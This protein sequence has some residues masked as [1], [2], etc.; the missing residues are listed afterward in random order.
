M[1]QLTIKVPTGKGAE[2]KEK[3]RE[4]NGKNISVQEAVT[5]DL[6]TVYLSNSNVSQFIA[7]IDHLEDAEI[8]LAPRGFI[9]LYPPQGDA[10]DQVTD[11]TY[12]SPIEIFLGGLQSVGSKTGLLV[13]SV[14]GA[15]LVW[16]G[17]YTGTS[18]LLV[19]AMLVAPFAGPAMN[20]ALAAA[21]GKTALLKRSLLRYFM[22]IGTGVLVAYLLSL[23]VD[24]QHA[25]P[26][27]VAVSQ[28]SQLSVLLPL[29]AGVAGG[30]NLIQSERDSLVSGAAVGMLVAASLAPPTGLIGMALHFGNWQLIRSGV[31]LLILQLAGI[32]LSAALVFRYMGKVTVKGVRFADGQENVFRLSLGVSVLVLAGLLYWQFSS[33]PGLQKS[34]LNT[35]ITE[36]MHK[37]LSEMEDVEAIEVNA[38][39]TRGTLPDLNPVICELYLYNRNPS[40]TAEQVKAQVSALLYKRIK[41]KHFNADPMFSITVLD[42]EGNKPSLP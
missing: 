12:R 30:I 26:M 4:L 6:V 38:R 27:M 14:A 34:S 28:V 18:Y 37:A 15:I 40:R 22:A 32:Q 36:V 10:P 1:R 7:S 23:F 39:F 13:Y 16:V 5:A 35:Q 19:A 3:A 29:V 25:T 33:Q 31:F 24:Q 17:L 11:V 21:S 8:N 42:Y 9:T 20:A 2:V 41:E